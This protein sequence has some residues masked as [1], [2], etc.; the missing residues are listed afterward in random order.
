M[1]IIYTVVDTPR[2][3]VIAKLQSIRKPGSSS[4]LI[5]IYS[6]CNNKNTLCIII[7]FVQSIYFAITYYYTSIY[8]RPTKGV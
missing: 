2:S 7:F 6:V 1:I 4:V 5:I 8:L 3:F